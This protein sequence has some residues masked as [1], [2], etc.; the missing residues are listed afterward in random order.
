MAN[1]YTGSDTGKSG[2]Q[3]TEVDGS[4]DVMGVSKIIVSDTTLTDDGGG[5]VTITTGGGGDDTLG[6]EGNDNIL[7]G[8]GGIDFSSQY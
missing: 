1:R 6:G 2:L 8:D 5:T 7:Y 3:V 4:P